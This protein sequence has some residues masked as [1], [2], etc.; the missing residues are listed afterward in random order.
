MNSVRRSKVVA[1][2]DLSGKFHVFSANLV[3]AKG[4]N[5][6]TFC[7][8]LQPKYGLVWLHLLLGYAALLGIGSFAV[9]MDRVLPQFRLLTIAVSALGFGCFMAYIGLFMHEAAHYNLVA[10]RRWNDRLANLCIG[11]LTGTNI[12]NYRPVHFEHHRLIGLPEDPESFYF[13]A[14]TPRFIGESLL[15]IVFVRSVLKRFRS[16]GSVE[17]SDQGAPAKSSVNGVL[18]LGA[19]LHLSLV[20]GAVLA[21]AYSMA[22]AWILSFFLVWPFFSVLRPILEHRD[23]TASKTVNYHVV[24]HGAV[25]RLFGDGPVASVLGGA[26]F[27]RHLLHHWEPSV[28]YTRL[29]DL[30]E[31]LKKTELR[32]TLEERQTTYFRVFQQL[33][34]V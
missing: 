28:S 24:P 30:E 18:L 26:G 25:N 20:A 4:L 8:T 15:G 5:C 12:K 17:S 22:I 13:T 6:K 1:A 16:F 19:V 29:K 21:G 3:D 32:S 10:D 14:L 7:K 27:N 23:E 11:I 2:N 34:K 9:W 31:Y 33:L